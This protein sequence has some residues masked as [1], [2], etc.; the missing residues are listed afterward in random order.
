[1][2]P[3]VERQPAHFNQLFIIIPVTLDIVF[4]FLDP[5]VASCFDFAF[6]GIPLLTLPEVT[7]TK[8]VDVVFGQG[9]IWTAR[10]FFVIFSVAD[11]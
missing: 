1:M 7:V 3:E 9:N 5:V 10:Q 11:A 4:D 2:L 8:D 6:L